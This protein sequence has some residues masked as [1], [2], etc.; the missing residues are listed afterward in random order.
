MLLPRAHASVLSA[1]LLLA[2][3][4]GVTAPVSAEDTTQDEERSAT[5]VLPD[6]KG[7][8]PTIDEYV[9][10]VADNN[11]DR[12]R[13]SWQGRTWEGELWQSDPEPIVL[14]GPSVVALPVDGTGRVVVEGCVKRSCAEV[15]RS[16]RL[17]VLRALHA[18]WGGRVRVAEGTVLVP[19]DLALEVPFVEG[20]VDW[21]LLAGDGSGSI[22][23]GETGYET[24]YVRK[25]GRLVFELDVPPGLPEGRHVLRARL[26]GSYPRY[27]AL[28]G[29]VTGTVVVDRTAPVIESLTLSSD[30]VYPHHDLY[31]DFTDIEVATDAGAVGGSWR[32]ENAAGEVVWRGTLQKRR[33]S[34][35]LVSLW[36]GEIEDDD[37]R[38]V[39]A[40][41][42]DYEVHAE[43]VDKV[44]NVSETAQAPVAVVSQRMV[45]RSFD[46][47]LR[48]TDVELQRWVGRCSRLK[49][50]SSRKRPGSIGL[51]SNLRCSKP[52][53]GLVATANGVYL[54]PS[55]DGHYRNLELSITGGRSKRH[56]NG[57][58][59]YLVAY[60]ENPKGRLKGRTQLGRRHRE[61]AVEALGDKMVHARDERPYVIWHV[62][63]SEGSRYDVDEY[64]VRGRY[65][66]LV[67]IATD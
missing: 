38:W 46:L 33:K 11:Y 22:A 51:Y 62:A 24:K 66:E 49:S 31:L 50:P 8:N 27:G 37:D 61:W 44:G 25:G 65:R 56:R 23:A 34:N 67:D 29:E 12:L 16:K 21:E 20:S 32:V 18:S 19:V 64:R 48:P 35:L 30:T 4:L 45:N 2:L 15:A 7:I 6:I 60:V 55:A 52:D 63:L 14:E 9:V 43:V 53:E 40:P 54:P 5:V 1:L 42:G 41:A 26:S 47:R 39:D 36:S 57:A 28:A 13:A 3:L 59:A 17:V 10:E 58:L